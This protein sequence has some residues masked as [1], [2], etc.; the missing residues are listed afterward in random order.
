MTSK[1]L[2]YLSLLAAGLLL[3]RAGVFG[4]KVYS[5]L[6]HL[7]MM[8]LMLLLLMM[9]INLGSDKKIVESLGTI[10]LKGVMFGLS[11][12]L[13]SIIFV[14]IYSRFVVSRGKRGAND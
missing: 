12:I 10:G 5:S 6:D 14:N 4:K 8:C 11:T 1:L 3:G 7:Q 2:L 9:G 13:F